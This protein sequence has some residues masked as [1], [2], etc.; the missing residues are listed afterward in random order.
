MT[1]K[2]NKTPE[3]GWSESAKRFWSRTLSTFDLSD[4][5]HLALLRS[6]CH[7]LTRAGQCRE[8][9]GRDGV[10]ARDRFDQIRAN[11]L[12]QE[13]RAALNSFRLLVRELGLDHDVSSEIRG[14]RA[15]GYQ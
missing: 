11:P 4:E 7:Q 9:I 12:I 3:N 15:A 14:P 6:A 10:V 2:P 5:H 13:E 8:A 1:E